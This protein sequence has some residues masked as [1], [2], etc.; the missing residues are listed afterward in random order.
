MFYLIIHRYEMPATSEVIV[1]DTVD[2]AQATVPVSA[3][4]PTGHTSLAG[5]AEPPRTTRRTRH[6]SKFHL[7]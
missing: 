5:T 2:T 4:S 3:A 1:V 6:R 7:Y